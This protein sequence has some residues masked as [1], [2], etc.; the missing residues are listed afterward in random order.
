MTN[1]TGDGQAD[2]TA[3]KL[4][5]EQ[6][7]EEEPCLLTLH[8]LLS[9]QMPAVGLISELADTTH[10]LASLMQGITWPQAAAS[11]AIIWHVCSCAPPNAKGLPE[12][13]RGKSSCSWAV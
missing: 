7:Q 3:K 4:S 10:I 8:Q 13:D 11:G 1:Q 6:S 12:Q 2:M 9:R 5:H